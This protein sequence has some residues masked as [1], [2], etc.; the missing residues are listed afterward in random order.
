MGELFDVVDQAAALPLP[1]NL[2]A[3]AQGEPIE[4]LV[5]PHIPEH[6]LDYAEA[7]GIL[8]APL[9]RVTRTRGSPDSVKH[10]TRK[11]ARQVG[12]RTWHPAP[13]FRER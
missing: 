13:R 9:G 4:P 11:G 8:R 10:A 6:G 1:I 12:L 7:L 3:P 5:V 2:G